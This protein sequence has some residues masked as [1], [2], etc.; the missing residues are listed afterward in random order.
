MSGP[1]YGR[2]QVAEPPSAAIHLHQGEV[3]RKVSHPPRCPVLDQSDLRAQGI[4]C[5]TFIPGGG[6]PDSLGSCTANATTAKLSSF[7]SAEDF[8]VWVG[9]PAALSDSTAC[10]KAAIRFYYE[11]THQTGDP[12][13]EWP[14]TDCGSSGPYVV[15]ELKRLDLAKGCRVASGAQNLVSL[16]QAGSILVGSPW[17]Y[18]WENPPAGGIID[19]DGSHATLEAQ[20]AQG[21]AGGHETLWYAIEKLTVLPTGAVDP[22]NTLIRARN[23]WTRGWGDN[24]DYVAHLS[25][26]VALGGQCD[27]RLLVR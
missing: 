15:S 1:A 19:G 10:E 12:G 20:L 5:S 21:I 22:F 9:E 7:L 14:P 25:T 11:C 18:A 17:L 23:S 16:M 8:Q 26:F 4:R 6:N 2:Y 27:F 3:L 24:G 13:Q